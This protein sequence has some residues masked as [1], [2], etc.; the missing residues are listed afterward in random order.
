MTTHRFNLAEALD[1]A[2]FLSLVQHHGYPTPLL[3]WT[4]SPFIAAYF[5][6]RNLDPVVTNGEDLEQMI[7]DQEKV[8]KKSFLN[9]IDLP[10]E[11]RSIVIRELDLMGINS[12]SLFPGLD[13]ACNQLK[14]RFFGT[15]DSVIRPFRRPV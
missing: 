5:A 9:A 6:F 3:D 11:E 7:L 14:E 1:H 12:G 8:T 15:R 13:G 4:Q 2:A 10:S